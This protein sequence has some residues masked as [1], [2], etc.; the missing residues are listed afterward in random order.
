MLDD[1]L[2]GMTFTLPSSATVGSI[3]LFGITY[4][5]EL[6]TPAATG[7]LVRIESTSPLRLYVRPANASL[8]Y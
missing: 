6:L 8:E 1:R 7:T 3:T 4:H 5:Y 2:L